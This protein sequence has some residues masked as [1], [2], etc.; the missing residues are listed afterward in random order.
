MYCIARA[1]CGRTLGVPPPSYLRGLLALGATGFSAGLR[2]S[3]LRSGDA[4]RCRFLIRFAVRF[5]YLVSQ[6]WG[7]NAMTVVIMSFVQAEE[8][9]RTRPRGAVMCYAVF[10]A[11]F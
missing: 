1:V 3:V 10:I 6:L 11:I 4:S 8:T 2:V 7:G 9:T 5:P